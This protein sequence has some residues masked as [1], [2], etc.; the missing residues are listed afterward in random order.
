MDE[1]L[2]IILPLPKLPRNPFFHFQRW[3]ERP[4]ETFSNQVLIIDVN[5]QKDFQ[6][7]SRG[8]L[9]SQHDIL[10]SCSVEDV[11]QTSYLHP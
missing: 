4:T 2:N 10:T 1:I 5:I 3:K 8:H 7:N 6:A 11:L 9:N